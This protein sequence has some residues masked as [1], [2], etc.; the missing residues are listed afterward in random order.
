MYLLNVAPAPDGTIPVEQV[1]SLTAIGDWLKV[2]GESIY[3]A[4]PSPFLFPPYA[5]TS[6][7]G[8]Y[9][10]IARPGVTGKFLQYGLKG[11]KLVPI[12]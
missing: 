8:T 6:K 7:P 1:K 5:I 10:I 2:N 3:D 9:T 11:L 4:D 12:R